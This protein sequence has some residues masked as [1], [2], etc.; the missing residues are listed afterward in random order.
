MRKQL[1]IFVVVGLL[2]SRTSWSGISQAWQYTLDLTNPVPE[3]QKGRTD[4]PG[5]GASWHTG[6]D[7]NPLKLP[8]SVRVAKAFLHQ[9]DNV[10]LEIL[11]ENTSDSSID[12]PIT[13]DI[14]RVEQKAST[15]RKL[16]FIRAMP[17]HEGL[18]ADDSVAVEQTAGSAR[19]PDSLLHLEPHKSIRVLM[20]ISLADL[21]KSL[22]LGTEQLDLR[23]VCLL[24][25]LD[26]QRYSIDA[27][28]ESVNS[29]NTVKFRIRNN[30]VDVLLNQ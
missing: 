5:G 7:T 8:L 17:V 30:Q 6:Q 23:I 4:M 9:N 20:P 21:K 13:R 11:I 16:F 3:S 2:T 29:L 1:I 10:V 26:D 18:A 24:W 25:H 15:S 19:V 12:L 22:P 27:V 14:S 28:S